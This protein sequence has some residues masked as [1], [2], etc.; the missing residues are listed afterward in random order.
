MSRFP[1]FKE[2]GNRCALVIGGGRVALRRA[3]AL[4]NFGARVTCIAE[5]FCEGFSAVN[6][7][8]VQRSFEVSDVWGWDIV[9]AATSD[10][11]LNASIARLA[12]EQGSEVSVADDP[13]L[14][15]FL[16][17]GIVRRGG[18]TVGI[19]SDGASPSAV[20]YVR[21]KIEAVIPDHFENVLLSME[22]ARRIAKDTIPDQKKRAEVLRKMFDFCL[23]ASHQPCEDAIKDMIR[24]IGCTDLD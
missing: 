21:E 14:S 8:C 13:E 15:T 23:S 4:S 22:T 5:D 6:A 17:P 12:K 9:I 11:I 18:M 7:E 1:F 20:K 24:C 3:A 10:R 2:I 19:S 16:F